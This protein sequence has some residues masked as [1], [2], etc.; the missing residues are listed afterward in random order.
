MYYGGHIRHWTGR[1]LDVLARSTHVATE[2]F[3]GISTVLSFGQRIAEERRYSDVIEAS[4]GYARRVA[5]YEGAFW[6]SS[7]L[8]GHIEVRKILP[9]IMQQGS[10]NSSFAGLQHISQNSTDIVASM[11]FL[12]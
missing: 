6:G 10:K 8:V 11:P 2:R 12:L 7:Y 5:I 3:G 1:Q 9:Q 4:Y